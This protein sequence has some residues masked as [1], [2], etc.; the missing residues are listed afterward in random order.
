M[1][2]VGR[3]VWGF[4]FF[5]SLCLLVGHR[6]S[7]AVS[8]DKDGTMTLGVRTYV[9]ARIGTERT[10]ETAVLLFPGT[11][12][13]AKR[14][15]SRT[16]PSSGSGHLRQNRFFME[17]EFNH[18]LGALQ[19]RGFGPL[20]LLDSLPFRIRG[21][22]YHMVFRGEYDGIYDWGPVE[23]STAVQ[24][25]DLGS[26]PATG[27]ILDIAKARQRLRH[28]GSDRERL[29]QAYVEGSVGELFIRAGRQILSWGATDG[30][31]L[32]DNINPVDSSFGGFLISLDERRVPLDMLRLQYNIG[33][34]GP[35]SEAFV[36]A[37]GAVDVQVGFSP[38][39]P[40]GS[41]WTLPNGGDPSRNTKGFI[42]R[43]RRNFPD[44]RG[45]GRAV[46]NMFDGT[47]SLA[48]YWTYLDTPGVQVTVK[49]GFPVNVNDPNSAAFIYDPIYD[50]SCKSGTVCT[51]RANIEKF[52][53]TAT[54]SAPLVQITGLSS[55]FAVPELYSIFRSE[56]AYFKDEPRFRQSELDPFFFH[57]KRSPSK[58]ENF[59][60]T[61]PD[62]TTG[63]RRTGDSLNAVVGVDI[64]QFIRF[65]NPNQT[66]FITTQFFYKHLMGAAQRIHSASNRVPSDGEVLPVAENYVAVA[67]AGVQG[68]GAVEPNFVHQPTDQFLQTLL[69]TTSYYSGQVNPA[70]LVFYDWGGA[71]VYQ[72]SITFSRDPFRFAIDYSILDAGRLKGGSGVS[73]LK[74]RD[75]IQ[76]RIEYVI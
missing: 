29:F 37:Y 70:F 69:F 6:Q 47:F 7:S 30:F 74:D 13:A 39:T 19:K 59:A 25:K 43:P 23:Y 9:N 24:M 14:L 26:N 8:L 60:A 17:A 62:V 66:F 41:P 57:Y 56:F 38:G 63:G 55:T 36:E 16:F 52:S 72:P 31:R 10:D 35:I 71:F 28:Y 44:M 15:D 42:D 4:A 67:Q 76:F 20:A 21:L 65:L 22:K 49:P 64:N 34:I 5:V 54:Q 12:S 18:D 68:F 53:S 27:G 40:A 11:D 48:H 73:L 58:P 32:L 51:E 45:G 75:N 33:N 50:N 2:R 1:L 3:R 61:N 46:W